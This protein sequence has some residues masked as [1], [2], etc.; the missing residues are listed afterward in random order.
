MGDSTLGVD[1]TVLTT[2]LTIIV[3]AAGLAIAL[4]FAFGARDSARNVIAGFYVRQN[5]RPGQRLTFGEYTG[6]VRSTSG[7]YTV[8][9]VAGEGG[10]DSTVALPNSLLI[11]NVVMGQEGTPTTSTQPE[12][13]G[14]EN[15][16]NENNDQPEPPAS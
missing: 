15:T 5:F 14:E 4:T 1:T 3:A 16:R 10:E 6:R 13:S 9:D 12:G 7:A 11:Q 2:S 8:L